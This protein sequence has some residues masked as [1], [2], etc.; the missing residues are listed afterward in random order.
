V[1]KAKT[2]QD[3]KLWQKAHQWVLGIYKL[4]GTFPK[5]EQFGLSSQMRRAAVS[6]PANF[7]EGF[8]KK[9]KAEKMR[10][11]NIAQGSLAESQYY[12]L[13]AND[14]GYGDTSELTGQ[15]REVDIMLD[16][17]MKRIGERE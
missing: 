10:Y 7:A 15:L 1:E 14:L 17:Y 8:R 9:T 16:V 5:T 6:V 11:Y 4:T 2:F 3:V 12:L 13:L